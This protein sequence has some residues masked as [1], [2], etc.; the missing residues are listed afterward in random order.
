MK[1]NEEADR[2]KI[3]DLPDKLRI[4]LRIDLPAQVYIPKELLQD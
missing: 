1:V 4:K 3:F 2:F